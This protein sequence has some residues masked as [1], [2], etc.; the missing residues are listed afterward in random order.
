M[1]EQPKLVFE[2]ASKKLIFEDLQP[3]LVLAD[4]SKKLVFDII[5]VSGAPV[6]IGAMIIESTFIV[7]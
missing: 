7:G 4:E 6:G 3:K 1:S 2:D 5:Q